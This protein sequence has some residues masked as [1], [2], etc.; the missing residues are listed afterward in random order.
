[1]PNII[2][3][4][5]AARKRVKP[6][7]LAFS[8]TCSFISP[9]IMLPI[10]GGITFAAHEIAKEIDP[11]LVKFFTIAIIG[12]ANALSLIAETKA[13]SR[14][15][16]SDSPLA[17]TFNIL[18]GRPFLSSLAGHF[19]NYAQLSVLSPIEA[20]IVGDKNII[21]EGAIAS[22]LTLPAFSIPLNTLVLTGR[23]RPFV[24][25]VANARRRILK[26]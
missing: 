15:N 5:R 8:G 7:G 6:E 4:Y 19:L 17:T 2:E 1:M 25:G 24:E 3:A 16:Y 23:A 12:L 20:S 10:Q 21:L 26:K 13:L 14:E 11:N 18:T 22:T 9:A